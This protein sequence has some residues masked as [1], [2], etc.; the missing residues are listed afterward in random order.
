MRRILA[1]LLAV[2]A[3]P[4]HAEMIKAKPA[5]LIEPSLRLTEHQGRR[6]RVA[7][8]L[9]A[10]SG[11]VDHRILD[12]LAQEKIPATLFVTARWL[13]RNDAAIAV[14]KAHPDLFEIEDH[15][16][17]HLA[18]VDRPMAIYGVKSVGS[19]EGVAIEVGG[20]AE[21]I[22]AAGFAQ[23]KWF[24][25]ATA[26]YSTS[27]VT[28]VEG[29][30]YRIAGYSLNGDGGSLLGAKEAA[31]RIA[32]ARDGDVIIAHINQPEYA[33]GSGV[34]EGVQALRVRGFDFV[35]LEDAAEGDGAFKASALE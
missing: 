6:P 28:L 35:R 14:L 34:V 11:K 10:C 29:M 15:G 26:K 20:G 7:L 27:A 9:D 13:K 17:E 23:P 1:L 22:V 2:S 3:F 4:V 31:R 16:R 30:G 8:T 25:G 33:A 18:V 12:F 19:P 21:A 5:A 24:R 32:R